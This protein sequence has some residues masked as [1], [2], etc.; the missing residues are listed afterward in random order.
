MVCTSCQCRKLRG[1]GGLKEDKETVNRRRE[2]RRLVAPQ[3]EA[4]GTRRLETNKLH[5]EVPTVGAADR[6]EVQL[7]VKS[8]GRALR[9]LGVA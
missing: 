8:K 1:G 4:V 2:C 5:D 9:Q 7:S 6:Q 3:E